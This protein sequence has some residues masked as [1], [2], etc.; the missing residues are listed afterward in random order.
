VPV[1]VLFWLLVLV[2]WIVA[3]LR[4]AVRG[5]RDAVSP[6]A[7]KDLR[8][9]RVEALPSGGIE[10]QVSVTLPAVNGSLPCFSFPNL[11]MRA[12]WCGL[13]IHNL[14]PHAS[15]AGRV[16]PPFP[17]SP[18]NSHIPKRRILAGDASAVGPVCRCH[19][20]LLAARHR[21]PAA[22]GRCGCSRRLL[23]CLACGVLRTVVVGALHAVS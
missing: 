11:H 5:L 17:P 13:D 18:V 16:A 9:S 10:I 8:E 20:T 6:A 1:I 22:A 19:L 3:T 21:A 15:C 4:C 23:M 14:S 2:P 12:L 7:G